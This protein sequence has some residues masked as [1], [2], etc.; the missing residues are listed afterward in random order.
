M[1]ATPNLLDSKDLARVPKLPVDRRPIDRPTTEQVC[2]E[3]LRPLD[4]IHCLLES[5]GPFQ[6][7]VY[8]AIAT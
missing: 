1:N 7:Q 6:D 8:V 3:L 4:E 2:R 5:N